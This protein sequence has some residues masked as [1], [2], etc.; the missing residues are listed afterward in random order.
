MDWKYPSIQTQWIDV[1]N[2]E[3][4]KQVT[5]ISHHKTKIEHLQQ[6]P[7]MCF[8][9]WWGLKANSR[10]AGYLSGFGPLSC[11]RIVSCF[12]ADT[13]TTERK[14]T[15]WG[16]RWLRSWGAWQCD[17]KHGEMLSFSNPSYTCAL[18]IYLGPET[19]IYKWLFQVDDSKSLHRKWLFHQTSIKKRLFRVPGIY[20]YIHPFMRLIPDS[21]AR[22]SNTRENELKAAWAD[23]FVTRLL[24][25]YDDYQS[26]SVQGHALFWQVL[27]TSKHIKAYQSTHSNHHGA[28]Y[29]M[30]WHRMLWHNL[31]SAADHMFGG[32]TCF[33]FYM[34][35]CLCVSRTEK[36]SWN[37]TRRG[38]QRWRPSAL[39][40]ISWRKKRRNVRPWRCIVSLLHVIVVSSWHWC[41]AVVLWCWHV[42]G[43]IAREPWSEVETFELRLWGPEKSVSLFWVWVLSHIVTTFWGFECQISCCKQFLHTFEVSNVFKVIEIIS[44]QWILGEIPPFASI[45]HAIHHI[46]WHSVTS[47]LR[48]G[49]ASKEPRGPHG[50]SG[51]SEDGWSRGD[52]RHWRDWRDW[53]DWRHG[54]ATKIQK[55]HH[56]KWSKPQKSAKQKA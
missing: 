15:N 46:S 6:I 53:R 50:A 25:F 3:R 13:R 22:S 7:L 51:S 48:P 24:F 38:I 1:K 40:L 9:L 39:Q 23:F 8:V 19:S 27:T 37:A 29:G 54:L 35:S 41:I 49:A 52:W 20:I 30:G 18:Y 28:T 34:S 5:G 33:D 42:C 31:Q 36:W 55:L 16:R 14:F 2:H 12:D 44:L 45:R 10:Q 43:C 21:F 56:R 47:S 26:Q 32:L 17:H 11:F 4:T